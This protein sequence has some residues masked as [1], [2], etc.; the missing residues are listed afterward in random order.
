[1]NPHSVIHIQERLNG[2]A[3][4]QELKLIIDSKVAKW[5][6]DPHMRGSLNNETL[7]RIGHFS[8]YLE[9][10]EQWGKLQHQIAD[11][12]NIGIGIPKSPEELE[13]M[14]D[15]LKNRFGRSDDQS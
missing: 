5:M 4:V 14:R 13:K 2:G 9:E 11:P 10:A 12:F 1:M 6:G 3:T 15:E 8:T 7:F